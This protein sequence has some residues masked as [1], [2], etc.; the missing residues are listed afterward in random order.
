MEKEWRKYLRDLLDSVQNPNYIRP[1]DIPDIDLY[2]DQVTSFMDAHLETTK[3]FEDDKLLTKTMINNY[4]K[5]H[6]LPN[7]EKK[8][9]SREHMYLLVFIYYLKNF[10]SISDVKRIVEPMQE[11]FYRAD[12]DNISLGE[13]YSRI[14]SIEE[15]VAAGLG[16][17]VM[18]KFLLS[19]NAFSDVKGENE[20]EFLNIFSFIAMLSFDVYL[21]KAM[22]EKIIDELLV[23]AQEERKKKEGSEK[24]ARKKAER[25]T[26]KSAE[27]GDAEET[28]SQ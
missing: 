24:P 26:E 11:M 21:K 22:I 23:P 1:H 2:M 27:A 18:D 17:D 3:R 7:P 28:V 15:N 19:R 8:K 16:Q 13:I 6:L 10:M 12:E 14:V 25:D 4:T 5:N 20:R 9:Y